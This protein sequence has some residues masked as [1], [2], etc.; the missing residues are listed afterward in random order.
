MATQVKSEQY[1]AGWN[2]RCT[3]VQG[4]RYKLPRYSA[5]TADYHEGFSDC[6][7]AYND[8]I[9]KSIRTMTR[10]VYPEPLK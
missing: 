2:Y 7:S 3:Y 6:N 5:K 10:P 8:A 4:G 9:S 1:K